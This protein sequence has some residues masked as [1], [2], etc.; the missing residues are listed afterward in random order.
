MASKLFIH[1]RYNAEL[2]MEGLADLGC[3][4]INCEEVQ[5]LDSTDYI[6]ELQQVGQAVAKQVK[7]E[8]YVQLV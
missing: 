1:M 2:S 7:P 3:G 8:H 4:D 5:Q 6:K